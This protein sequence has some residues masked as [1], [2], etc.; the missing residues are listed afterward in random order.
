MN[1]NGETT[2]ES[3]A[4]PKQSLTRL[5]KLPQLDKSIVNVLQQDLPL[6]PTPFRPTALQLGISVDDFLTRCHS[7]LERGVI[8]RFSASINHRKAGFNANGMACWAA[9]PDVTDTAGQKLASL[10]EVSHCYERSTTPLWQYNLFAMIH[11]LTRKDCQKTADKIS[12]EFGL[13][14]SILLFSTRE[15]KKTRIRYTA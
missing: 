2:R 6:V 12:L 5:A 4:T 15:F 8:R 10:P 1:D 7:L 14:D 11:K 13:T 9:P 3:V